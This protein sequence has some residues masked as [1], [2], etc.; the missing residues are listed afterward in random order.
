MVKPLIV[1]KAS[2][3]SGK[4][5]TLAV[6]Y[7]KLLV[8]DPMA[9]R[10]TLAVTFTNKA[11]AEMK[12]RIL[13]QLYGIWRGLDGSKSYL[14]KVC[15]DLD[16]TPEQASRQAGIALHLL[17]HNYSYFRVETIDSFFQSVLRNLARELEL[18]ANLRIGLNDQQV[19]EQAVDQLIDSLSATDLLLQWLLKYIMDTISDDR[20]WNVIGQ[21]KR[22][23]LT[24]FRDF[25]KRESRRLKAIAHE[26]DF[27]DNYTAL[28]R[29]E[30]EQARQ[31]MVQIAE[32][33]FDA[34][35]AEGLSVDDFANKSRG[36]CSIF[37]KMQRGQFD[38]SV[39]TKT[40]LDAVGNPS[41][42]YAKSS[43]RA[44]MIHALAESELDSLLRY[45]VDEQPRQW[46]LYQSAT[47][48]LRHLS[49]LR[50]LDSIETKVRQLNEE[51]NRFLLSDTQQLLS[52]L[53]DG[54]DSPFIFEKIGTRLEHIMIDEFQDTSTVQWQNF[55]VLLLE[56]MSHEGTSNLIVGDVK[57]S[58]YRW[59][60]GDWRLL[61]N[62]GEQFSHADQRIE[63]KPLDTNYRSQQNIIR[64]NN[65]FFTE[66]ARVEEVSA[67][68][69][70]CQQWPAQ[71]QPEGMVD[72]RLLP[73]ADYQQATLDLMV[74]HID[75]LLAQG[76]QARSIAILVR[77]NANIPLIA[78][79]LMQQRP[80]LSVISDEAFRLDASPAVQIIIQALRFLVHPDDMI[81]RAYLAKAY[82]GDI[83]G[84]LPAEYTEH[85]EDLLRQPLYELT[86]RLYALF[87]LNRLEDQSG[88]LCAFYDQVASYASEHTADVF[89]FL[90][91]WDASLCSKTIQCPDVDGIRIISIHKSKGLE[92]DNVII[93]FCDWRLEFSDVLWCSPQEEPFSRLPLAPID[94]SQKGMK[95]TIYEKDY[96]EE[97]QQNV[98]DNLNLLYVAFTRAACNLFVIGKRAAKSSRSALIEQVLPALE[99]EG[100]TLS[101]EQEADQPLVF[102]F[103]SASS[104]SSQSSKASPSIE[105]NPF[106]R[107]STVV[108]VGIE[109]FE[110]KFTF[111]QSN[112]SREFATI[113]D[114]EQAQQNHY[115]QLGN[116]LHSVFAGIR[117]TDDI[118]QALSQLEQEGILYDDRLT[119]QRLEE[120]IRKRIAS[121]R[122]A[123][124]FSPH[125]RLY[126]ECTILLPNGVE[127][128]PD[129]VVTDGRQ[130]IVIDFK[131]GHERQEYHDQ[132]NEYMELLREMG[133]HDVKGYLWFVYSNQ[134]VEVK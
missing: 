96:D 3:G 26:K 80:A 63:V 74:S 20:S 14:Q 87:A 31:R 132:V 134:I 115:V 18:T 110:P 67:Y 9:F 81:A 46:R 101:G 77:S 10:Q 82:S 100:A 113:D 7:I 133:H 47:L 25:Y 123:E 129:R 59:R 32:S 27:F 44:E 95:G 124:W 72:I 116:V 104:P 53:I 99:L 111:K 114:D 66:A 16:I 89:D 61:A 112:K 37:I 108:P 94:Y 98:V 93:P 130:T 121:P 23:G 36:V 29:E 13:S 92:F 76:V 131:F 60:S 75:R 73:S 119:R 109:V 11:T 30:R 45:A 6:E 41:K 126:N 117:T 17:L 54:S 39:L 50:L 90:R 48:T 22:F 56:A 69:D 118:N 120:M 1:Y 19:E 71:R 57:Q 88:Y 40:V 107:P 102:A 86:E 122:V 55:K 84:T 8:Q 21:I 128:R 49:Q 91:E 106:L 62:I 85:R 64:F 125:W 78:N 5:F 105:P 83:R 52:D 68:D 65:A 43:P 4:T 97:H 33:F 127:R 42:W 15:R 58:I 28:L 70:V 12:Q 2:A 51:G 35:S 38:E 103:G 34:I 24:I 79:Y